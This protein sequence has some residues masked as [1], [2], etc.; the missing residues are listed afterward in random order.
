MKRQD[1]GGCIFYKYSKCNKD[2]PP[3]SIT[4][5]INCP[6]AGKKLKKI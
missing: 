2:K 5:I 4:L 3:K 1:C 6:F